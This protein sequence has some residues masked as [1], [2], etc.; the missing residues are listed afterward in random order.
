VQS[1][2]I[3][4]LAPAIVLSLGAYFCYLIFFSGELFRPHSANVS[5]REAL[6]R[7]REAIELDASHDDVLTAYWTLRSDDLRLTLDH[8]NNWYIAMPAEFPARQ[9]ALQIE[10]KSGH[11]TAVRIRTSDGPAPSD[12][13]PD[14]V[15]HVIY[16]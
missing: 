9:W 1:R 13:P 4:L 7:L 16:H 6:L 14:K 15:S 5:N 2:R 12:G 8:P 10:F 11:V 3:H